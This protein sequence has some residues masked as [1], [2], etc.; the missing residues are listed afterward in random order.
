MNLCLNLSKLCLEYCGLYF[1]H[2]VVLM[3][4]VCLC[5]STVRGYLDSGSHDDYS[6]VTSTV[7]SPYLPLTPDTPVSSGFN[8]DTPVSSGFNSAM[9]LVASDSQR[10]G[11]SVDSLPAVA[12]NDRHK[13]SSS[14]SSRG[15]TRHRS[16]DCALAEIIPDLTETIDTDFIHATRSAVF[17]SNQ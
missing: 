11:S 9:S 4:I 16:V 12:V 17:L 15:H 8:P 2:S 13:E 14:S 1:R 7:R 10:R 5:D 6:S 3:E